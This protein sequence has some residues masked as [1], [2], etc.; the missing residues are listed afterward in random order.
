V[1]APFGEE[2]TRQVNDQ[3]LKELRNAV[4][5]A[6]GP[7]RPALV[8]PR[9]GA[10]PVP[11]PFEQEPT[12]M[13]NVNPRALDKATFDDHRPTELDPHF[14]RFLQA[15]AAEPPVHL[16]D[17]GDEA[18]RMANIDKFAAIERKRRAQQPPA[19][20]TTRAVNI[21]S[22]ASMSDVDWDID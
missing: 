9:T 22:D 1:P 10:R 3:I 11:P 14:D 19:E 5:P 4:P 17:A 6:P 2:P 20:E 16:D 12:R 7:A 18:T 21:R 13:A 15:A 8:A